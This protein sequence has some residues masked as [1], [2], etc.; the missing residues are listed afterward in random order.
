MCHHVE[1]GQATSPVDYGNAIALPWKREIVEA[2]TTSQHRQHHLTRLTGATALREHETLPPAGLTQGL[3]FTWPPL[4]G[5]AA[6]P[7]S[8]T[9]GCDAVQESSEFRRNPAQSI[10]TK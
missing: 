5:Y 10:Y 6:S 2:S 7:A 9:R 4:P 1:V 8:H 3:R